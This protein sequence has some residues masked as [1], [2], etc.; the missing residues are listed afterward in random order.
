MTLERSAPGWTRTVAAPV[1]LRHDAALPQ[2]DLRMLTSQ[3][4]LSPRFFA[5]L[6]TQDRLRLVLDETA[7]EAGRIEAVDAEGAPLWSEDLAT[8]ASAIPCFTP[9]TRIMTVNGPVLAEDL[10][11]GDRIITRDAGA[12]PLLWSGERAFGWRALGL[13]AMLRPVRIRAGAL[14]ADLPARDLLVSPN[15]LLLAERPATGDS[16]AQEMFLPARDLV[17]RP[18]I[19]TAPL[20]EVRYLHLLL[21]RHHAI[22]AEGCWSESLR[23]DPVAL[24]SLTGEA[25]ATLASAGFGA[26]PADLARPLA[27]SGGP[28]AA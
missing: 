10:R 27:G 15:H 22:L 26:D 7:E 2:I 12:Q 4:P 25:R 13:L 6:D 9:G 16:P 3:P 23:T 1:P 11:P 24:A 8:V 28:R 17:G 20:T 14:G 21:D 5:D 18:G 19:D